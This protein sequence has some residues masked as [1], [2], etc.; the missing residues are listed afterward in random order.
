[1]FR[2][3]FFSILLLSLLL[4]VSTVQAEKGGDVAG[5]RDH[6]LVHRFADSVIVGYQLEDFGEYT[7][8]TGRV[9][10]EKV[11]E[12]GEELEGKITRIVY[13]APA[14]HTT[15]ELFRNYETHLREAGFEVL[16]NCKDKGRGKEQCGGYNFRYTVEVGPKMQVE[17]NDERYLA[18]KLSRP[19]GDVYVAVLTSAIR[20]TGPANNGVY[21]SLN[22]IEVKGMEY[23]MVKAE[24]MASKIA[25][26]GSVAL[27]GIYFDFDK[28]D[29]QPESKPTLDQIAKLLRDNPALKLLVVGHT[30]NDG[31]FDYNTGLSKRR[32]KAVVNALARDYSI[33][34]KR[35]TPVGV[36]YA[37]PVASNKT[38]DGRAKNR[39]VELVEN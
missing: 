16:F 12:A 9:N 15:L 28:A 22:M 8:L 3:V 32:A 31:S 33:D 23:K 21:T 1:M 18:A 14:S 20:N 13:K 24:E 7:L 39:R 4:V 17:S 25:A 19:E 36:S 27:Y 30:D 26:T 38:E 11:V 34:S 35:L 10:K 37:C 5:S 29:I 6:P 2:T